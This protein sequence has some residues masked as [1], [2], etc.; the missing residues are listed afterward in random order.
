[1]LDRL[2]MRWRALFHKEELERELEAELRFHLESDA[3]HN[4][5]GGMSAEDAHYSALKSFGPLERSKEECR[6][7]R[8]VRFIEQ[9]VQDLRYAK[10]LLTNGLSPRSNTLRNVRS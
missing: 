3:T 6:D 8:R 5:Q 9:F 1:M 2:K 4:V 10:R 7:A